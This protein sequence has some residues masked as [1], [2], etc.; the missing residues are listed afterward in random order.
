MAKWVFPTGKWAEEIAEDFKI[1]DDHLFGIMR[2]A[3]WEGAHVL[4]DA[5]RKAAEAHGLAGGF[6][7]S[8]MRTSTEGVQTS[9]GFRDGGYFTNR[10][11][12]T[13][14]YDLAANVLEY[15]SSDGNHPATHFM[16]NAYKS[17]KADAQAAMRITFQNEIR[18]ILGE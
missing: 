8:K 3:M 16:S 1:A 7:V 5:G 10:W 4:A 13:T 11:G 17:A 15:G 14:P 18:R 2:M 6:G 9:V 12:E